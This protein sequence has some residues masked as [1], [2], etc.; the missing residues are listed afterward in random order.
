M[1][2]NT[3]FACEK[4]SQKKSNTLEVTTNEKMSCCDKESDSNS[5]KMDCCNKNSKSKSNKGCK[6][7]CGHSNC[8]ISIAQVAFIAPISNEI[9]FVKDLTFIN[10]TNFNYLKTNIA[11]GFYSLWLIPKIG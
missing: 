10:K 11:D 6:G 2:S 8:T 7:K 5:E 1:T 9:E 3:T 4:H